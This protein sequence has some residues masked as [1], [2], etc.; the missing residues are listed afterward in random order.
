MK[1]S[2]EVPS[3][4]TTFIICDTSLPRRRTARIRAI[5]SG[6]AMPGYLLQLSSGSMAGKRRASERARERPWKAPTTLSV[7]WVTGSSKLPPA[8]ETVP[9]IVTEPTE[10]SLRRK[11][12]A[13][14]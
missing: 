1:S 4:P 13:R 6:G 11:R 5:R 14:S 2:I 8:G 12:P 7:A 10:P 9:P 3:S